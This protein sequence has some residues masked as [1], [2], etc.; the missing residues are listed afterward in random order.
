MLSAYRESLKNVELDGPTFFRPVLSQIIDNIR[1]R[2]KVLD[3]Y[4]VILMLTDGC[5]HDMRETIDLI[6]KASDLPLSIIIIGIGDANFKNMEILDADE[7]ELTDSFRNKAKR[8]IVQF[9]KYNEFRHD[10]AT[11]AENVLG[12]V[13]D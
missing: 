13:P 4:H 3:V 2:V 12:E 9:V 11:L 6:V 8:D 5:I 1:S 7:F 10:F